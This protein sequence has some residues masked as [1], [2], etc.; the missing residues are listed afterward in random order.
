[1]T[2]R[3]FTRL[4]SALAPPRRVIVHAH[5]FKNAGSTFD[6]SLARSLPQGFVD[7]RDDEQMKTGAGYLADWLT[8]NRDCAALSSHWVTP[9]LPRQRGLELHLCMLLRDP[10]E[11]MRSVYQFERSQQGVETPG[12]IRAK[13][14]SFCEYM[15]WQMQPMPG[16]VVKNY[17]TRYCSGDYLGVDLDSMFERASALLRNT[18]GIGLV[19]RYDES[20]VYF[21]YLLRPAFPSLDL[22][23]IKQNVSPDS[24]QEL[25]RRRESVLSE[26]GELADQVL[27]ANHYDLQ[28]FELAN[29]CF[30]QR[31]QAVPDFEA[32][33]R[34]LRDRNQ[35]LAAGSAPC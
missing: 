22:S 15:A 35:S 6:W 5:M 4:L 27:A 33:L 29:S 7:H 17:Q 14:M 11:R 26:L 3:W 1:M 23:Y 18:P 19:H 24:G 32:R 13:Q 30:E 2:K 16:P 31:L 9:P 28:L 25:S 8:A 34:E 12:S 10:I 20:M 21:E